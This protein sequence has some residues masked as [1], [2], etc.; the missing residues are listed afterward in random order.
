VG[1]PRGARAKPGAGLG[2]RPGRLP[3][4]FQV[5]VARP[6]LLLRDALLVDDVGDGG[7]QQEQRGQLEDR[8]HRH[9]DHLAVQL[10]GADLEDGVGEVADGGAGLG[11]DQGDGGALLLRRLGER[12]H[13]LGLAGARDHQEQVALADAR[14]DDLADDEDL[15]AAVHQPHREELRD[16]AGAAR[17]GDED[18]A[19]RVDQRDQLGVVAVVV[20]FSRYQFFISRT[21]ASL[22]R[23]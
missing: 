2:A 20:G 14:G 23:L 15:V 13:G 5:G 6:H 10:R 9:A 3:G 8:A 18:A 7:L 11:R 22:F 17:A 19:G 1:R 4:L 12:E 21:A 16:Q